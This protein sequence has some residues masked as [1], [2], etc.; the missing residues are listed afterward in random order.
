MW[1]WA[2]AVY[3]S[4]A[5]TWVI[6]WIVSITCNTFRVSSFK[7]E[8]LSR[9]KVRETIFMW[10][11]LTP[12][13]NPCQYWLGLV[14]LHFPFLDRLGLREMVFHGCVCLSGWC[15]FMFIQYLL[16]YFRILSVLLSL[17]HEQWFSIW[18]ITCC[19]CFC[20]IGR[21][22]LREKCLICLLALKYACFCALTHLQRHW[23][24]EKQESSCGWN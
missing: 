9:D 4:V 17:C 7:D 13:E 14:A 5:P 23:T 21:K 2:T 6:L 8:I 19:V 20:H 22:L 3:F 11:P 15:R 18:A 16:L 24:F 12:D 1:A 10:A